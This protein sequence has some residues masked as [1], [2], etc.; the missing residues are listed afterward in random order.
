MENAPPPKK[1]REVFKFR[2][3]LIIKYL[4]VLSLFLQSV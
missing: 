3:E 1:K 2:F 4:G